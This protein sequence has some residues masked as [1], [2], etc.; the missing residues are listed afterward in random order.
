M[1]SGELKTTQTKNTTLLSKL[2]PATLPHPPLPPALP[3]ERLTIRHL[4]SR[5]NHRLRMQHRA[6]NATKQLHCIR[7]RRVSKLK[8]KELLCQTKHGDDR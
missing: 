7:A 3:H 2:K 1:T 6:G 4:G 8:C 5:G